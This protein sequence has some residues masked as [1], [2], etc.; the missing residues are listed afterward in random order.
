[1]KNIKHPILCIFSI[2]WLL[3]SDIVMAAIAE[4][5]GSVIS[6]QTSAIR[7]VWLTNVASDALMSKENIEAAV[8]TCASLGFNSIFVVTYNDGYTLYPSEIAKTVSGK[9]I[10]PDFEGRDP[11]KE[12]IAAAHHHNIKVFAWFEFGFASAHKDASG[13]PILQRN[14]AWA[15]RDIKGNITEKNG[16]Y[17]LNPFHPGVQDFVMEMIAEVVLHYDV[18]GIQGDDRLPALPSNGGYDDYTVNVYKAEHKNQAPPTNYLD[19]N[20]IR[21]RSDRLTTF[22]EKLVHRLRAIDETVMIS[23][24]PSIY[25]W[26]EENYLQNWPEW[27]EMGLVD[28]L[29]P[30]VYRYDIEKYKKE[31][32]IIYTDL[33]N[34]EDHF[35][36]IP[37]MLLQVDEYNPSQGVLSDMVSYNKE[38]GTCGEVYFFYEGI[39]KFEPFFKS[40]YCDKS[41][42]PNNLVKNT[43]TK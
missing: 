16:F 41:L 25:P 32:D 6:G 29:I 27:L 11:L 38:I 28:L 8:S 40:A 1:M 15:S 13:G 37:G 7:G 23:M 21:W 24:A 3:S 31:M 35:R 18:D 33:V 42:F 12:V 14:P 17:W 30:Q 26:S 2:L 4:N 5:T 19:P 43:K 39:K 9:P 10:H 22:L 36:V 20:W 34:S